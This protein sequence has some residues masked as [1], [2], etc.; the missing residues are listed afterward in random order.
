MAGN[1]LCYG[2]NLD[3]LMHYF[4]DESANLGTEGHIVTGSDCPSE[5]SRNSWQGR[6]C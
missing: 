4:R 3:I 1:V 2:D 5:L 6:A